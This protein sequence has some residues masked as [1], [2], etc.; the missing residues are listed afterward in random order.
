MTTSQPTPITKARK[1]RATKSAERNQVA[2]KPQPT[3]T[4]T[5]PAAAP[6]P[7]P[8][9][10]PTIDRGSRM[11][12]TWT[13]TVTMPDGT[14]LHCGHSRFGHESPKSTQSCIT[15]MINTYKADH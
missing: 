7:A 14:Q 2:A 15:R 6:T 8:E 10:Q 5:P 12:E 9:P 3:P 1:S 11:T 4:P 13:P